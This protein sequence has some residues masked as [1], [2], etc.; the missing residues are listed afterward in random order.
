MRKGEETQKIIKAAEKEYSTFKKKMLKKIQEP[1]LEGQR[2]NPV[3]FHGY[4]I[5]PVLPERTGEVLA[6][7]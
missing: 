7:S 2:K 5:F 6:D 3:L 1:Y 4:G